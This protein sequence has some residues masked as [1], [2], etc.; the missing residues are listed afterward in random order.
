MIAFNT[1]TYRA[2][3]LNP[4]QAG[5][6]LGMLKELEIPLAEYILRGRDLYFATLGPLDD[7][8][9]EHAGKVFQTKVEKC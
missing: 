6:F 1:K 5:N 9:I 3:N 7:A 8:L 2:R 4:L